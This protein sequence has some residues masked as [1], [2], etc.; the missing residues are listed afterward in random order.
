MRVRVFGLLTVTV[1]V[2]L[3]GLLIFTLRSTKQ[4]T[5]QVVG[6]ALMLGGGSSN[7][8]DRALQGGAVVDFLNVGIDSLRTGIF[9]IADVAILAGV[10]LLVWPRRSVRGGD[11]RVA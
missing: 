2:L 10:A 11:R 6:L 4:E 5:L 1:G 7:W 3:L 8:L 9:N